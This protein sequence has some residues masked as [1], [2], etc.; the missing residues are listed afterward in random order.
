MSTNFYI[1]TVCKNVVFFLFCFFAGEGLFLFLICFLLFSF[2]FLFF[3]N[4]YWCVSPEF[5]WGWN[6]VIVVKFGT[7]IFR[8]CV[9]Y[10]ASVFFDYQTATDQHVR[11][12]YP[13]PLAF[14]DKI[15]ISWVFFNHDTHTDLFL[16][17]DLV[18]HLGL[19]PL[20][21]KIMSLLVTVYEL[22]YI[23]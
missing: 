16:F 7:D 22:S 23:L 11:F 9:E 13:D 17:L 2:C 1:Y 18:K 19:G 5:H 15:R 8:F 21:Y 4:D 3:F 14:I 10:L 12:W 6:L 20:Q